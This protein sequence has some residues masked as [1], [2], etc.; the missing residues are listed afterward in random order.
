LAEKLD[1]KLVTM[2]KKLLKAFPSRAIA[3]N[4]FKRLR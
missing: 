3:L 4:A 2:D 1:I